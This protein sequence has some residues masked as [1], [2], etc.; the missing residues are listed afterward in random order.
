MEVPRTTRAEPTLRALHDLSGKGAQ[1]WVEDNLDVQGARQDNVLL[2]TPESLRGQ[3]VRLAEGVH[4]G[5]GVVVPVSAPTGPAMAAAGFVATP[6]AKLLV[7]AL[8]ASLGALAGAI[9]LDLG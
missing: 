8:V 9:Y 1:C 6:D 2:C 3:P 4:Q 7:A 5:M